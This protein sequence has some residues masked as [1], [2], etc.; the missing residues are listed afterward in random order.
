MTHEAKHP[1]KAHR[2]E[3]GD[4]LEKLARHLNV[5]KTTIMRWENGEVLIPVDRLADV[6][7]ITGIPRHDLRPDIFG[8]APA[9]EPA[10]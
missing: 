7:R 8:A 6:E 5:H 10:E 2:E 3:T 4:T 1:L 9:K